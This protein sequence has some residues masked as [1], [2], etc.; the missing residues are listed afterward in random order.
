MGRKKKG[1]NQKQQNPSRDWGIIEHGLFLIFNLLL[2]YILYM[3]IRGDLD[4]PLF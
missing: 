1:K 4:W 3:I 2:I